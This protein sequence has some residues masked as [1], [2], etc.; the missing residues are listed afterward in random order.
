MR[1]E[2]IQQ[3]RNCRFRQF[4]TINVVHVEL[5]GNVQNLTELTNLIVDVISRNQHIQLHSRQQ[6]NHD[7][8]QH[9]G[10][11]KPLFHN[12]SL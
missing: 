8:S 2:I 7:Q 3:S 4:L 6:G 9:H 1:I 11:R 5:L 10:S 12:S